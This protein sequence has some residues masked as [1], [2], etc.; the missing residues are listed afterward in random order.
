MCA[1]GL[2]RF[3]YWWNATNE[4]R[5]GRGRVGGIASLVQLSGTH[6]V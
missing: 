1:K 4:E 6:E 5:H 3:G 2:E